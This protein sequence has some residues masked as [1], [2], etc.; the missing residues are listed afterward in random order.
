MQTDLD[1]SGLTVEI[2]GVNQVGAE[3][4]NDSITD[5]RDL[6]WLQ[7]TT[8]QDVWADWSVTYRDVIIVGEDGKPV[9]VYNLTDNDLDVQGNYDAL[10]QLFTDAGGG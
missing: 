9:D 1:A 8:D 7:E 2:I 10:L 3:S 6:A 5:G 4:G